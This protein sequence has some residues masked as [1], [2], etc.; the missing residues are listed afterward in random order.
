[1]KNRDWISKS[2][3]YCEALVNGVS[4]GRTEVRRNNLNPQWVKHLIK[5]GGLRPGDELE[6]KVWDDDRHTRC[7]GRLPGPQD[8]NRQSL[9]SCKLLLPAVGE[10]KDE[11]LH[12]TGTKAEVGDGEPPQLR[13]V[14][15][16][17]DAAT[18]RPHACTDA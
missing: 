4:R 6:F 16:V 10:K 18:Y 1:L 14:L 15:E 5:I 9:G 17:K 11:W 8:K 12:L 2:D 3:P 7:P 13:V